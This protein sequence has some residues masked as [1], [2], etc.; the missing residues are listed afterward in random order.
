MSSRLY[1]TGTFRRFSKASVL[2]SDSSFPAALRNALV[3]FVFSG[4]FFLLN[5]LLHL[6]AQKRN[7]CVKSVGGESAKARVGCLMLFLKSQ[8]TNLCIVPDIHN[9]VSGVHWSP[10]EATFLDTH[11]CVGLTVQTISRSPQSNVLPCTRQI[12]KS[13]T[14]LSSELGRKWM[15]C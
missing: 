3:H 12:G 15:Q 2:S 14:L 1:F 5:A 13:G 8:N 6:D 7:I 10:T 9:A 4:F 11:F